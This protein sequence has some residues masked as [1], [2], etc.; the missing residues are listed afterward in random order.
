ML[1]RLYSCSGGYNQIQTFSLSDGTPLNTFL[2]QGGVDPSGNGRGLAIQGGYVY[3]TEVP[4]SGNGGSDG[5]HVCSYGT[6]GAGGTSDSRWPPL[7]N[8]RPGA[9]IQALSFYGGYLYALTGYPY[10][11]PEVYK[12][13]PSS[14][15][16]KAAIPITGKAAPDCDGFVVLLRGNL[17][18]FLIN[19]KDASPFYDE[20]D[21]AQGTLTGR[22]TVDLTQTTCGGIPQVLATG[23]A[24]APDGQSLYFYALNSPSFCNNGN[25]C[26]AVV[27]TDL[28]GNCLGFQPLN[29]GSVRIE[30]I[31]VV[32]P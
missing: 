29:I 18:V 31:S 26:V 12:I 2:P 9:G 22:L 4:Q 28:N 15:A 8:P 21:G 32:A 10:Q 7:S 24:L 1:G 27:Q 6:E 30:N 20:Y 11:S 3:Y 13:D 23:A 25:V 17:L 16:V 19:R 14:G 5:I